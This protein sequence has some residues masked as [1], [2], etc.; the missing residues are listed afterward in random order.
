[1]PIGPARFNSAC[2]FPGGLSGFSIFLK[3]HTM[4][5][6]TANTGEINAFRTDTLHPIEGVLAQ[7]H[8]GRS[9]WLNGVKAG[10][11]PAPIFLSPRRPVWKQS[12]IDALIA[13]F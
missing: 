8:M 10:K 5:D 2:I 12:S 1:M 13:S 4:T 6:T 3:V 7:V 9:T 11:Y